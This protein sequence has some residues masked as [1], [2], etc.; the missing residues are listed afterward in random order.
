MIKQAIDGVFGGLHWEI[1]EHSKYGY[2]IVE[3][4]SGL[5]LCNSSGAFPYFKT[6]EVTDP[7][8]DFTNPTLGGQWIR[9]DL[10]PKATMYN[11]LNEASLYDIGQ[12]LKDT[13]KISNQNQ[14]RQFREVY[15]A[16][17]HTSGEYFFI[18]C[19]DQGRPYVYRP[20]PNQ[21]AQEDDNNYYTEPEGDGNDYTQ[22]PTENNQLIDVDSNTVWF[23]DGTLNYIDQLLYDASTKTYYVDAHQEYN[24]ENNTYI[25]NNYHYEYHIDYTS[26]TYIGATEEYT[27]TYEYYYEL[28]DG[29]S[30]ADLTAEE[31][32]ALNT[33]IDVV[34]YI[35]SADDV[36]IRALYHFDGDCL[37]DSYWNYLGKLAWAEGASITYM[38]ANAFNGALYLDET[39]HDFTVDLPSN[40]YSGDFT[41]QFR[42]YQSHTETPVTDSY[43]QL[44]SS[45]VLQMDG[46]SFF[47][48]AGARLAA[49]H[50]GS[51]Q[52]VCLMR[53]DGVLYYFVNGVCCGSVPLGSSLGKS[54]RFYFGDEQQTYKYFDELRVV[55]QA[56]Y[57]D[58]GYTPSSVPFDTNLSLVLPDSQLPV[59]DE[60][61]TF[62]SS[63]ENLLSPY[64]LDLMGDSFYSSDHF[65]KY[66]NYS[67]FSS[68]FS[69]VV[70]TESKHFPY[71]GSHLQFT[72]FFVDPVSM[73]MEFNSAN[74]ACTDPRFFQYP[75]YQRFVPSSGIFSPIAIYGHSDNK[76][77]YYLD[78]EKSYT[79]S[80]VF[81][82]GEVASVTFDMPS[83]S[84][85]STP[86]TGSYSLVS[87]HGYDIGVIRTKFYQSS[88]TTYSTFWLVVQPTAADVPGEDIVYLELVEGTETDLSAEL[89]SAVAPVASDFKTPTLAVRTDKEITGYQIGGVRPSLPTKGLIW[90][91]VE[92]GRIT[93]LQHY[94]GQAWEAV[95][96]RIWTGSRWVP[97]YA[98]DV[99]LLKDMYDV[100]EADP[101]QE[102][103]Y[104]EQG[105]WAWCQRF[106][107][108]LLDRL[109]KI[110]SALGGGSGAAP[111]DCQHMYTSQVTRSP[112]CVEP[113]LTTYTCSVCGHVYT[114]LIDAVG[115]DWILVEHVPEVQDEE[116][117]VIEEGCDVLECSVCGTRA[118]DYGEGPMEQDVFDA[119]G[120]LIAGGITWVLDKL[121]ELADSLRGITEIFNDF[122]ARLQALGGAFPAFFGAFIALIPEDL[123]AVLW[124]AVI[125]FVVVCVW[126]KWS[127]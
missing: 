73:S 48:G 101:S 84:E 102:Y 19:D 117:N 98:Y 43:I 80:A 29:R 125:A 56:L 13:G 86:I 60:Y 14:I 124:F 126:K 110:L 89:V 99:L 108:Q 81:G 41:L 85:I 27:E 104:T 59:A 12:A 33:G 74:G 7:E 65:K 11:V 118:K 3:R 54:I 50:V 62:H 114:E 100:I 57:S 2:V 23:P 63:H 77:I 61:W 91:L 71:F 31:L 30:S 111:S 25:T 5:T 72:N 95:D 32:L 90:A 36:S 76:Y 45:T 93:S 37:D 97:Y 1:Q 105:F 6:V 83:N 120:D 24:V 115:H 70:T 17:V 58:S 94:N 34:P 49:A 106:G 78:Q 107:A 35:R 9:E 103:I 47:N 10:I 44:G 15:Q 20:D 68:S 42:Y 122:A 39:A 52:E 92:D 21:W 51:W 26:V 87:S 121:T 55:S 53:K 28:P 69:S 8:G 109:D 79:F 38:D 16:I 67:D 96:G 22:G 64:G 18:Y 127:E 112:G 123:A 40:L 88:K 4:K 46:A 113:G 119:L 116:G 75:N 66:E 82:D